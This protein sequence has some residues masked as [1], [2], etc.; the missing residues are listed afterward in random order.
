MNAELL[1][2]YN[3]E[4]RH[5]RLM[6]GEFARDYPKIAG[7]LG[8]D[9]FQCAD[10]YVE[11]LLEGFAFLSARVQHKI[12]SEY[13]QFTQ[14]LL[15]VIYPEYLAPV[16][17]TTIVH[18]TP[19]P[20]RKLAQGIPLPRGTVMRAP[21]TQ[22]GGTR[23]EF[24]TAHD[25]TLWPLEIGAAEYAPRGGFADQLPVTNGVQAVLRLQLNTID[26]GSFERLNLDRL[27]IFLKGNSHALLLEQLC[28]NAIGV[29]VRPVQTAKPIQPIP[30]TTA[31]TSEVILPPSAISL[32]GMEDENAL[33][34]QRENAFSGFRLLREYF[35]CPERFHFFELDGLE[36]AV[37][38]CAA[39]QLE[40]LF[41]F[42]QFQSSLERSIRQD[43]FSL[44]C[45]P[46]INLFSKRPGRIHLNHGQT[47]HHL[48][49]DRMRPL[50]YEVYAVQKVTGIGSREDIVQE[51]LPFYSADQS[52]LDS[53]Q[54][55]YFSVRRR[56]RQNSHI[57]NATRK[58]HRKGSEVFLSLVDAN[59]AP[60]S[61]D[62][63]TLSVETLCTNRHLCDE[64][65]IGTRTM[66]LTLDQYAPILSVR[67]VHGPTSAQDSLALANPELGW[68]LINHL[69]MNHL[70]LTSHDPQRNANVL[71]DT[72]ALYGDVSLPAVQKQI[73]GITA[74]ET[75]S[76]T[77]R[78]PLPG[79]LAFGRGSRLTV[80]CD[81]ESFVGASAFLLT[82]VL[83]QFFT[84]LSSI[85]SFTQ[86]VLKTH[87][88]GEVM[89]WAPRIGQRPTL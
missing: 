42:D 50:D 16:P 60:Y 55:A 45:T 70:A 53:P 28:A 82:A 30:A 43:D 67:C 57:A 47:E 71:R 21:E 3:Q 32:P 73:R 23:C 8:L 5:L 18:F 33:L 89:R 19:D 54:D 36:Q 49:P 86:T 17:S 27:P 75:E 22:A 77:E 44:F 56:L 31:N 10:P 46:A 24:R 85:N 63:Q 12:N 69:S 20:T 65:P 15:D 48:I 61:S 62:I 80:T 40:V 74:L 64:L 1:G 4:L 84:R 7:R 68:R 78:L 76:V 52:R 81:E 26:G 83:E 34:P 38:S 2:L 66:E 88:R 11:R 13:P 25:V 37:E 29:V 87:Q 41:L 72:L 51:F 59:E 79:P 14:H 9:Q 6:G 39:T 58:P 35:A